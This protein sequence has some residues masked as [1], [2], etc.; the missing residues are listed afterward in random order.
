MISPRKEDIAKFSDYDIDAIELWLRVGLE[1]LH[2]DGVGVRN[3]RPLEYCIWREHSLP[4]DLQI[5]Y[6]EFPSEQKAFIRSAIARLIDRLPL[7]QRYAPVFRTLIDFAALAGAHEIFDV[8]PA[9]G[10]GFLTIEREHPELPSLY[11]H[12]LEAV[13]ELSDRSLDAKECIRRLIGTPGSFDPNHAR[14]ALV[15]LCAIAPEEFPEHMALMRVP[16]ALNFESFHP[17][18]QALRYLVDDIIGK[19]GLTIVEKNWAK[20]R[21][22]NHPDTDKPNDNWFYDAT[23]SQLSKAVTEAGADLIFVIS[24]PGVQILVRREVP[25]TLARAA[26]IVSHSEF[27]VQALEEIQTSYPSRLGDK[28]TTRERAANIN[29]VA[30]LLQSVP[31]LA[32]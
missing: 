27:L 12:A 22:S 15:A 8:L 17:T 10:E 24:N 3:F 4:A 6:E 29:S 26:S 9:R 30:I 19:I 18:E 20:L 14:T 23:I 1:G 7:E 5:I 2:I 13:A 25:E 32:I 11:R 31:Q 16:I 21:I 28:I